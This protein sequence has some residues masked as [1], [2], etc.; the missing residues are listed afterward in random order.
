MYTLKSTWILFYIDVD[1]IVYVN[2]VVQTNAMFN[3]FVIVNLETNVAVIVIVKISVND[4]VMVR[5]IHC[6]WPFH[7]LVMS[8]QCHCHG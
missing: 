8:C 2:L 7:C 3:V 5:V 4:D 6:Q 1:V